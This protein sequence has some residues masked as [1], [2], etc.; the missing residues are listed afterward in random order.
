MR[1]KPIVLALLCLTASLATGCLGDLPVCGDGVLSE[2]EEC[3]DGNLVATDACLN[4]CVKARCGDGVVWAGV[5]A[6]DD[7]NAEESDDCAACQQARCGDGLVQAGVEECD[8]ANQRQ[9]D[10]CL[11]TCQSARCG[12][13]VVWAGREECDDGNQVRDDGCSHL[14]R[15][16]GCGDGVLQPDE[17]CDDGNGVNT[18]SCLNSCL[19]AVCGDGVVQTGVEE[20]DD[21]RIACRECRY[22][23]APDDCVELDPER[24]YQTFICTEPRAWSEAQDHC[25][26]FGADLVTIDSE[27]DSQW[28]LQQVPIRRGVWW[29]GL[30]DIE[31]EGAWRWVGRDSE[32]RY[33]M[34]GEPNNQGDEDCTE[35]R[36]GGGWNG[37][38]NDGF[39]HLLY[40]FLCERTFP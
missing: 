38:W 40:P 27:E 14:C 23:E 21:E 17:E 34:G 35:L 15:V 10:A 28:L 16:P 7:G 33:W 29:I 26:S 4:G 37:R 3:D 1:A 32:Y 12:D 13:G 22:T 6:C 5:E 30:N 2:V 39:C 19:E 36:L 18:D 24:A 31:Q 9:V 25:E 11:S 20:C 8:D